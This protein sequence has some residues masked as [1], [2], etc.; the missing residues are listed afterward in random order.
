ME[1]MI[2][3]RKNIYDLIAR[4]CLLLL[5]F[6]LMPLLGCRGGNVWK[7]GFIGPMTGDYANYGLLQSQAVQLAIREFHEQYGKIGGRN[8]QLTSKCSASQIPPATAA[9]ELIEEEHVTAVIGP[10]FSSVALAVADDFQRAHIPMISGSATNPQLTHKGDYIFRTIANDNL[11]SKIL[12]HYLAQKL[13]IPSLGIL[14]TE[15]DAFSENLAQSV[16]SIFSELG[17]EVL[18]NIGTPKGT[19]DFLPYLEQLTTPA[20]IFLPFYLNEFTKILAQMPEHL[21]NTLI[22]GSDAIVVPK[23]FE[24]VGNMADDVI[25]AVNPQNISYET[26]YF[27][28]LYKVSFGMKPDIF[29]AHVYDNTLIVLHAMRKVYQRK[30]KI[31]AIELQQEIQNTIHTGVSG[32][33]EFD[34]NGDAK[35]HIAIKKIQNENIEELETYALKDG[36]LLEVWN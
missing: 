20:A 36:W 31:D 22:I 5:L 30:R 17:G 27:E 32:K 7:I 12:A 16:A 21:Q 24:M 15:N 33:I 34:E 2:S 35:R 29:S 10:V 26:R 19:T 9:R 1:K 14:Y 3:K 28:A 6:I 25:I 4:H 23:L 11:I 18:M 13:Q 8:I